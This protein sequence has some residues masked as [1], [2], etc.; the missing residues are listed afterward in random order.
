MAIGV[1][2]RGPN[3]PLV[4]ALSFFAAS[5]F[6]LP[7]R[8]TVPIE[9]GT[10]EFQVGLAGIVLPEEVHGTYSLQPE[11]RVGLFLGDA[12]EIQGQAEVRVWPL[13]DVA[14]NY[15]GLGGNLLWY[16]EIQNDRSLYFLGGAAGSWNDPPGED[17]GGF[18][19]L[20]RLGLGFKVPISGPGFLD[21]AFLSLEYRG[22]FIFAESTDFVSGAAIGLSFFP[23]TE[24]PPPPPP[25]P[26]VPAPPPPPPPPGAV[27]PPPTEPV[28][29]P[30]PPPPPDIEPIVPPDDDPFPEPDL[31][32]VTPPEE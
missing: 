7:A 29:P 19:P 23:G 16:P 1:R 5:C 22:E 17:E 4:L 24:P 9:E 3:G 12:L 2:S 30:P 20:G 8:A 28:P 14:P 10:W 32:G 31:E 6:S 11:A 25:P 15:Y 27:P 18:D 26:P 21:N 13:G